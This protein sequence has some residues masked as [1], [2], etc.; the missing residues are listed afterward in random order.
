MESLKE[1]LG[2]TEFESEQRA[3]ELAAVREQA[4]KGRADGDHA[5]QAKL[6]ALEKVLQCVLVMML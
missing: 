3:A 2:Q 4:E 6:S 1:R 5:W